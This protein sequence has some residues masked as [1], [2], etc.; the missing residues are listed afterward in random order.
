M[1]ARITAH[2][3]GSETMFRFVRNLKESVLFAGL[4]QGGMSSHERPGV[5]LKQKTIEL[6]VLDAECIAP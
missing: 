4:D 3:T 5:T 6:Y 2:A 1:K